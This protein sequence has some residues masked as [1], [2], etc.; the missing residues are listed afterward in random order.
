M[1][2]TK[3]KI[4]DV[5][6]R[7]TQTRGFN[8]FSY[9]DLAEEVGVK[10]SSIHYHFKT[11]ADLALALVDR[12]RSDHAAAFRELDLQAPTAENRLATMIQLFESYVHD[13]KFCLCGMLSAELQSVSPAVRR[14]LQTYFD[15]T[16]SWVAKQLDEIG[17]QDSAERA[18]SF[19]SNLEGSLL[20]AR[21]SD[22]ST[23]IGSA[24]ELV[25]QR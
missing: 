25:L 5:A 20:L 12:T 1:P 3:T 21:L 4:L 23:L 8:G 19:V 10:T 22:D 24:M 14:S 9:L 2:D 16:R 13:D 6:E 7:L 18:L 11:K 15:D 17:F